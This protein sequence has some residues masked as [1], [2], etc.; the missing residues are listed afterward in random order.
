MLMQKVV[1]S[2]GGCPQSPC[3][4]SQHSTWLQLSWLGSAPLG[5]RALSLSQLF[6]PK[7][8]SFLVSSLSALTGPHAT[9][10]L[11]FLRT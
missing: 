9:R 10:E 4:S 8:L 3:G 5:R 7:G 1:I 6:Q 11:G 2:P